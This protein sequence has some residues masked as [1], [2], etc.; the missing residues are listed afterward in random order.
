MLKKSTV[1]H[2]FENEQVLPY[3][4]LYYKSNHP[5]FVLPWK[6][7][8]VPKFLYLEIARLDFK[9]DHGSVEI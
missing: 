2:G 9:S 8:N 1:N 5:I 3:P 7:V 6:T 4:S